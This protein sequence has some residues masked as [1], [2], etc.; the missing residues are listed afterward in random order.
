MKCFFV[1]VR[2]KTK[3]VKSA[4]ILHSTF[5][6]VYKSKKILWKVQQFAWFNCIL[7]E[8][9]FHAVKNSDANEKRIIVRRACE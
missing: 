8:G 1:K 6:H 2:K 7:Y 9:I 5:V 4:Q 3:N